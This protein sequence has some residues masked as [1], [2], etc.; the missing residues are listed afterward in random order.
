MQD[1]L[2]FSCCC[3]G[4]R[5]ITKRFDSYQVQVIAEETEGFYFSPSTRR[6]FRVRLADFHRLSGGG[7]VIT[8]T[9]SAGPS[10]SD[11]REIDHAYFCKYGEIVEN[12][13]FTTKT[14]ARKGLFSG[15]DSIL[16]CSCHG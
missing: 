15:S 2:T 13:T 5:G 16:N 6:F 1:K 7:I 4:C 12:Y 11:G 10:T 9:K 8:S 3:N 14:Q